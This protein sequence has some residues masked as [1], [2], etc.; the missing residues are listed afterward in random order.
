[1]KRKLIIVADL[2]L[3]KAYNADFPAEQSPRLE[4]LDEVVLEDAHTR[5]IDKLSD[6]AGRHAAPAQ[7]NWSAP[8]GDDHNMKLESKRRLVRQIAAHI[9]RLVGEAGG[10]GCWLATQKEINHR[11]LDELSPSVREHIQ[12]NLALDLTKTGPKEVLNQFLNA[13]V[14]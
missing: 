1:M 14:Y 7:K 3:L 5:V 8:L 6:L 4:Q 2:G 9:E 13:G 11:I 10:D 12:K